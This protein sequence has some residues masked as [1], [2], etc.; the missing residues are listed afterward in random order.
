M[1]FE[2]WV[3]IDACF[4]RINKC[5]SIKWIEI[6]ASTLRDH[7]MIW[8][9]SF[10]LQIFSSS[11]LHYIRLKIIKI[12]VH[13]NIVVVCGSVIAYD[14]IGVDSFEVESKPF[15]KPTL[16]DPTAVIRVKVDFG[17][18]YLFDGGC[19]SQHRTLIVCCSSLHS[20]YT[21]SRQW[22]SGRLFLSLI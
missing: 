11:I 20:I 9:F 16:T 14:D 21:R 13:K 1:V 10:L 17:I 19:S 6:H 18:F 15:F 22:K 2:D 5:L 7:S 8:K 4:F 3:N 12:K